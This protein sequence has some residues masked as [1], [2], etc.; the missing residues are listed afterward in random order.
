MALAAVFAL[1]LA[2]FLFA[3]TTRALTEIGPDGIRNRALVRTVFVPWSDVAEVVVSEGPSRTVR[4]MRHGG[5]RMTLAAV[6]D[7]D[8]QVDGLGLD[9]VADVVRERATA[10]PV[11]PLPKPRTLSLR[12]SLR[13]LAWIVPLLVALAALVSFLGSSVPLV[14]IVMVSAVYLLLLAWRLLWART[15]AG[16][17]G[18]RNRLGLA[19]TVVSWGDI[20]EFVVVPTLFG[21]VVRVTRPPRRQFTLAAPREGLLGRDASLDSSVAVM[22]ALAAVDGESPRVRT[23]PG[24]VRVVWWV[25]LAL[26]LVLGTVVAKPWLEPWWPTRHGATSLPGACDLLTADHRLVPDGSDSDGGGYDSR[27][28]ATSYCSRHGG[29]GEV[30]LDL[31]LQRRAL[32]QGGTRVARRLYPGRRRPTSRACGPFRCRDWATRCGRPRR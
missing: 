2:G 8:L 6:P 28:S 24:G 17:A 16:P 21:R 9:D 19:T 4:I 3:A 5:A 20:E 25:A 31:D 27:R 15:V 30:G 11:A 13:P 26:T 14:A 29:S 32:G 10:V 22:R 1:G 23:L 7:S 18:L 12:P